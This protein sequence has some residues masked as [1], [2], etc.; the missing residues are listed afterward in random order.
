VVSDVVAS[1]VVAVEL[2]VSIAELRVEYS[3]H[4]FSGNSSQDDS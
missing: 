4:R 2:V 3:E 1:G